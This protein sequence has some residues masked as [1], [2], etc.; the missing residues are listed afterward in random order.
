VSGVSVLGFSDP[1]ALSPVIIPTQAEV[2]D[3]ATAEADAF[4]AVQPAPDVVLVHEQAQA[5]QII[6][7]ARTQNQPL[8]VL[9]GHDHVQKVTREGSV[10]LVDGG[11]AGASGLQKL[12]AQPGTPY[13]FQ[14]LEFA[15]R[16]GAMRLVSVTTL[17]YS[18]LDGRS[19]ADYQPIAP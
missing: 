10:T 1:V 4:S 9:Y 13:T 17:S 16:N 3:A 8:A 11:S 19:Q 18:G 7:G 6:D 14:M 12:G 2:S 5:Q 15:P